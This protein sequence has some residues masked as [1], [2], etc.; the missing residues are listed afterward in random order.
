MDQVDKKA[1]RKYNKKNND[2]VKDKEIIKQD[3]KLDGK[4]KIMKNGNT[5]L[6]VYVGKIFVD[7]EADKFV[8]L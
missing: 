8:K 7:L 2:C 1:K 6:G 3:V 5:T 4:E